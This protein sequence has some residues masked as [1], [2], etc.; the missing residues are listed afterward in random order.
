DFAWRVAATASGLRASD[1]VIA[2]SHA[3]AAALRATYGDDIAIT[4]VHNGRHAPRETRAS[5]ELAVLAVGRLWDD[6]KNIA[7][8]D[9]VAGRLR[10]PVYAA[11]PTEGPN[12]AAARF[13]NVRLLGELD[14]ATLQARYAE[15]A[16]FAS[17][18]LY[19]PFGLG[20][21]EA[22]QSGM[23]LVLSDIPTF[24]E[25]WDGTA[26]F[27]AAQADDEWL[28]TLTRLL[29][30]PA[31]TARFG[32]L[33]RERARKYTVEAMVERTVAVH[34]AVLPPRQFASVA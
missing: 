1:A 24:R 28:R 27:V 16:V 29:A 8:L 20:V 7:A 34:R 2:P 17:P 13:G 4:V 21:L 23:A 22:A 5:R 11:G 3:F 33:A 30:D 10:A 6:G 9:R 18:A 31:M 14:G 25:L 32:A 15:T 12:G 19:E 26:L